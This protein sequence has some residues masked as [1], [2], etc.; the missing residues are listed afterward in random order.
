MGTTKWI[1][2]LA[3]AALAALPAV[4]APS[5]LGAPGGGAAVASAPLRDLAAAEGKYFGTAMTV[6]ELADPAYRD[7]SAREAG[8]LTVGNELK[9]DTTEPARGSFDFGPGDQVVA[10]GVAAGQLVRGH[11]LVWHNQTPAWVKAL[12]PADLHQAMV[13]HIAAVAGHYRGKLIA[14]DVVN[15]AFADDGTRRQEFWQLKLGDGYIADAFRAAHAADP[16]AKLY[17]NDYN[18]DGIGAKSDAVYEMVKSFLEEGVPIHGVGLQAH[19][20]VG[21]VPSTVRQNI[22]RFA[23]L[24]LEVAITELD[25]RMDTPADAAKLAAQAADYSAVVSACVAVDGC[26]GVTTW[27]LSDKYSW[28]PSVFPGQGAALPFDESF[29]PKPAYD[30]VA[31]AFGGGSQAACSAVYRV[32][33]QWGG[34]FQGE[35]VVT[36]GAAALTGWAVT[37]PLG[38]G[39]AVTAAWN[40]SVSTAGG[41]VTARNASY[42]GS[43]GAGRSTSFGFLAS[44]PHAAAPS[45]SCAAG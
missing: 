34:G 9:W 30:A 15:E 19:L 21:Q 29:R 23:D 11:T 27:G 24:G 8:V 32:V 14:W 22:Q 16:T 7:L 17:Y 18:I 25:V 3:V 31:A 20:I 6:G 13:D 10:G 2:T 38:S 1:G 4:S 28:I 12:E 42:N 26:A 35:V 44:G 41:V 36:A 33:G 37:W 43:V 45:V 40:A 5:A 39:Q